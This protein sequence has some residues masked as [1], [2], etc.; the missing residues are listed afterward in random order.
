MKQEELNSILEKRNAYIVAPAGHGK[1][2]KIVDLV[3]AS[4]GKV[5]LLTHTNA[6]VD[7]LKK[8]LRKR[9]INDRKFSIS[10]IAGFCMRWC[11]AYPTTS[12]TVGIKLGDRDFYPKCYIGASAIFS[13]CWAQNV[14]KSTYSCVIVDE[15]Q[16]CVIDQHNIF[17][18]LNK[19]VPVYVLGDP[20]QAIFGWAGTLVSWKDIEF[21][22]LEIDTYPWR[23][24]ETNPELGKFLQEIRPHLLPS[25][26][27]EQIRLS[28]KTHL[29]NPSLEIISVAR[30]INWDF[31]NSLKRYSNVLYISKWPNQQK[32]ICQMT[33]GIFQNDEPQSLN[34]LFDI[35][36]SLDNLNAEK[37]AIIIYD[38]LLLC[39]NHVNEE[40]GSYK[41]HI[42]NG[43]FDFVRIKKHPEFG[44]LI[45]NLLKNQTIDD[46]YNIL[47]WVKS[48]PAFCI[49]RRE[50]FNELLRALSH[51]KKSGCSIEDAARQIRTEPR[52]QKRYSEFKFLS[53]RT[54]LSKGLEYDCVVIDASRQAKSTDRYCAT[55]FYV[56]LTR[57][58]RAIYIITD[59]NEIILEGLKG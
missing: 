42:L 1:T 49:Y 19:L 6:G 44:I 45:K 37:Q 30:G 26:N 9:N 39:A 57:A 20:L 25:L 17:L 24:R 11:A 28:V 12:N 47:S 13:T 31:L 14:I 40:I 22:K 52:M 54:V 51:A 18:N 34:E 36:R 41:N 8:R 33:R 53:S 29:R 2:E 32:N 10:T 38:F 43:D 50:L 23:W 21:E 58:T 16:D 46:I 15:Y 27:G 7:A 35:S 5:L 55:D 4:A 56:A 59:D 48:V 3:M